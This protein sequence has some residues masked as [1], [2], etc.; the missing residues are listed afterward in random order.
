M[1]YLLILTLLIVTGLSAQQ[2]VI[3]YP[4]YTSYWNPKTMIPD[5][6]I[7]TITKVHQQSHQIPRVNKFHSSGA[8]KNLKYD[9]LHSGYDQGHNSPYDD[10]Y[11]S[12]SAE[13]KC[14]DFINMFP[15]LHK[16]NGQTWEHLEDYCRKMAI[17]FDSCKVKTSWKTIDKKIGVDSVVVPLYC[18]KEIW[19]NG[20]YEKYVMPNKDTVTKHLFTYYKVKH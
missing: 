12:D 1:K 5:S 19:Y 7:W 18:V 16:L 20:N 11:Y 9:Y 17:Q 3:K 14:F 4:G 13:Y 10:N 15:Q 2:Q 6:V 8:R